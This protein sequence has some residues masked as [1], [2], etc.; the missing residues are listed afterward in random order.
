MEGGARAL[1][2]ASFLDTNLMYWDSTFKAYM[3]PNH[4]FRHSDFNV[5]GMSLGVEGHKTFRPQQ[6]LMPKS[7]QNTSQLINPTFYPFSLEDSTKLHPQ[8]G[9]SLPLCSQR[10]SAP[11]LCLCQLSPAHHLDLC[12]RLASSLKLSLTTVPS[13]GQVP[14]SFPY[15]SL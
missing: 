7:I 3:S 13:L 12:S 14:S 6:A 4:H 8:S 15:F 10:S 5:L 2:G 9:L 11:P 1:S